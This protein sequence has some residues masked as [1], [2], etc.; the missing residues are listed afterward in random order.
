MASNKHL[1]AW[2]GK[3]VEYFKFCGF[4]LSNSY[5]SLFVKAK[6]SLSTIILLYVNDMIVAGDDTTEIIHLQEESIYPF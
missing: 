2:Y 1:M 3:I 5:P 6:A 4:H